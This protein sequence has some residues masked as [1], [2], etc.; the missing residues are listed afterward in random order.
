MCQV[1]E[2]IGNANENGS[3]FHKL[4]ATEGSVRPSLKVCEMEIRMILIWESLAKG[5]GWHLGKVTKREWLAFVKVWQM[6][7]S[8]IWESFANENERQT[9]T[10]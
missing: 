2:S 4:L 3:H 1:F 6:R 10:G 9:R 7:T 8:S 5:S